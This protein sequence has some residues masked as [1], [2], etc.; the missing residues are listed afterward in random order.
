[1]VSTAPTTTSINLILYIS[2]MKGEKVED[3][4]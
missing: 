4:M 3:F 1:M 2:F